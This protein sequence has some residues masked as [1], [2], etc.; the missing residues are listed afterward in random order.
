MGDENTKQKETSTHAYSEYGYHHIF[1]M[2][3]YMVLSNT[4][5]YLGVNGIGILFNFYPLR[6]IRSKQLILQ[7]NLESAFHLEN[8]ALF[9]VE[10]DPL[11]LALFNNYNLIQLHSSLGYLLLQL[12]CRKC[13]LADWPNY[14][15][16]PLWRMS[17]Q[18]NYT[19]L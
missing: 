11:V 18:G 19:S 16:M 17:Y 8:R 7:S 5:Q 3:Y 6:G 10:F 12:S 13:K 15:D 9:Q 4:K 2:P 14:Q 1:H